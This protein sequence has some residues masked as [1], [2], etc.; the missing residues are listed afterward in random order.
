MKS[1]SGFYLT[2][3][4]T[5]SVLILVSIIRSNRN[6]VQPY[7]VKASVSL[8]DKVEEF[9]EVPDEKVV[10]QFLDSTN[11]LTKAT[12]A[13]PEPEVTESDIFEDTG[14]YYIS[15]SAEDVLPFSDYKFSRHF[16]NHRTVSDNVNKATLSDMDNKRLSQLLDLN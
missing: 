16:M 6:R 1:R 14:G 15:V 13:A 3:C 2:L 12:V 5:L 4:L 9:P 10:D 11:E 7:T 8:P